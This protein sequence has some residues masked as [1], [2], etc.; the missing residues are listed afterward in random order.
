[1]TYAEFRDERGD[2]MKDLREVGAEY[3]GEVC[4]E[5]T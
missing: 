5:V 2:G 1:M 3:R 4:H